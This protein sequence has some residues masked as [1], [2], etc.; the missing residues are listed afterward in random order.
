[1]SDLKKLYAGLSKV[2]NQDDGTIRVWGYASSEEK[3]SDGEI[4]TAEAMKAALPDY[5]KWAN[6]R[7]MHQ[8][9]A[10]GTAIE[11]EVQADGRTW[12]G[13]HIVDSEAV[14]KVRAGVYKGFSIGGKVTGRNELNKSIIKGIRLTEISLVDRPA[15]PEAA[16]MICKAEGIEGEPEAVSAIDQIAE[17]LNKGEISAERLLALAQGGEPATQDEIAKVADADDLA[18]AGK[19]FSTATKEALSKVHGA[20]KEC[21]DHL[22]KLGYAND[23]DEEEDEDREKAAKPDDLAKVTG[24]LEDLRKANQGLAVERDTLAKRV[25]ELEAQPAPGKALLKAIGKGADVETAP[26]GTQVEIVK[27]YDGAVS[28]A[29]SLIKMI[30]SQGGVGAR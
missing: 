2:E 11:A 21:S 12:F 1:M 10:A 15:N 27:G 9:K 6:V 22:D 24:E 29:A 14:K 13:A 20:V 16:I 5:M 26:G 7:E 4:V 3:D 30:H 28:E 17:W 23:D 19:R 25:K 18:K 8:A